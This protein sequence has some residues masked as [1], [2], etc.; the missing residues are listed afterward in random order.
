[1]KKPIS[2]GIW[3]NTEKQSFWDTLPKIIDWS[4]DVGLK[5]YLT[6]R[7]LDHKN[8]SKKMPS[9]SSKN[10][11]KNLDFMLVLGGDGTFLSLARVINEY[12]TPI[13]GIHLGDLGFLAKVTLP[14]LFNRL[15]QVA[16]GD[17][18]IEERILL[19]AKILKNGRNAQRYALNDIVICNGASHRMLKASVSVD[20]HRVC[21]YSS[22]GLIIAT[23]TGSTAYSLSAG[24][25][26][27][28]PKVDS[29]IITP[30]APHSLTSRPLVVP[31]SSNIVIHFAKTNDSIRFIADGQVNDMLDHKSQILISKSQNIVNL[32]DFSDTDYFET[33]RKKMGWG[34]RGDQ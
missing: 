33:L 5:T 8:V 10:D 3:G 32:I 4:I 30:T 31:A 25:P 9:I 13:L 19:K 16:N 2:F 12:K 15:N 34:K 27:V 21:E 1:M 26:I 11:F 18:E 24:G 22:D 20:G 7:I 17:Y 29:L 14:D 23:P 6:K 28:T